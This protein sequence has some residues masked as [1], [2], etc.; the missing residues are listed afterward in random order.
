M[1]IITFNLNGIRSAERK[2]FT[3]WLKRVEPWDVVCLQ[4]LKAHHEAIPARLRSPRKLH[5]AYHHAERKG[6]SGVGVYTRRPV[7]VRNGFGSSEFDVE[8]RYIEADLGSLSV[9]SVYFPSGS[10]SPAR[11]LA[12]QLDLERMS[13]DIVYH[14]PQTS[15][16]LD[17]SAGHLRFNRKLHSDICLFCKNQNSF[18]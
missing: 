8:G 14:N 9:I 15:S 6:Y 18:R 13:G 16:L 12:A 2:G 7:P 11:Q 5:A 3:R 4:E 1:R 10:N 17:L